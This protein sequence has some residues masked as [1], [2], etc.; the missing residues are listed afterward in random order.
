MLPADL[1]AKY[2]LDFR[3]KESFDQSIEAIVD[4]VQPELRLRRELAQRLRKPSVINAETV[5]ELSLYA[6]GGRDQTIQIAAL[7]GLERVPG[8]EATLAV[9]ERALDPWGVNALTRAL[10]VLSRR[11]E[12]G[13]LLALSA[14]LL[15]DSRFFYEKLDL[16]LAALK[17]MNGNSQLLIDEVSQVTQDTNIFTVQRILSWVLEVL[18]RSD[19]EDVSYGIALYRLDDWTPQ[20]L[21]HLPMHSLQ[22]E[23]HAANTLREAMA[24][25][26]RRL[27]GLLDLIR[28]RR[29]D[30]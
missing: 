29:V 24:Y 3:S 7:K 14:I 8:P 9:T 27:P 23:R 18:S 25:A 11:T 16:L 26:E 1:R 20:W 5:K 4:L 15:M 19:C 17:Q 28:G 6:N 22:G 13:G 12:D 21:D 10:I 2:C 30:H